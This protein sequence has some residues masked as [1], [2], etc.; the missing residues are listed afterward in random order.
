MIIFCLSFD[1]TSTASTTKIPNP[2]KAAS[3]HGKVSKN[4]L[5]F[6]VGIRILMGIKSAYCERVHTRFISFFISNIIL[7]YVIF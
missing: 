7:Q 2:G 6:C 4:N 5:L 1:S 3:L